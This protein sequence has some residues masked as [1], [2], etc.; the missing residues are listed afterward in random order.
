MHSTIPKIIHQIWFQGSNSVPDKFIPKMAK[1]KSYHPD[2]TYIVWDDSSIT[3]LIH[4]SQLLSTY[5]KFTYLHQ[6]VDFAKYVILYKI[7]GIYIDVDVDIIKPLT[8][9]I[10]ENS[11]FDFIVSKINLNWFESM[12]CCR[13]S[14][15]LNNGIIISKAGEIVLAK[16]IKAITLLKPCEKSVSKFVCIQ[17]TTGP[18]I[19]TKVILA[20][21]HP[22]IK[23]LDP[24]YLEPKILNI[25]K[26]SPQTYTIHQ[27][28]G[29]WYNP[30]F[31]NLGTF[32]IRYKRLI[33]LLISL[34]IVIIVVY[35]IKKN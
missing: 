15:C 32:Y 9:L 31:K 6:K 34:I 22:K 18:T 20:N 17:N 3:K 1:I 19:F 8:S 33:Y 12:F 25:G 13:K 26:I 21:L 27:H 29:S 23:L 7:G 28:E 24:I 4:N 30:K 11:E 16:L 2:W 14:Y 5:N 10:L 35:L